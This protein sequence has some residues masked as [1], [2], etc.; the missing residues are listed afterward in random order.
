M[1]CCNGHCMHYGLERIRKRTGR[2]SNTL[3]AARNGT[4]PERN[5]P[6]AGGQWFVHC[7]ATWIFTGYAW[8]CPIIIPTNPVH[9][10]G[11]SEE[12]LV[13]VCVD[14]IYCTLCT[15]PC[16]CTRTG[17]TTWRN[18][19]DLAPWR[20]TQWKPESWMGWNKRS[21][22]KLFKHGL[23]LRLDAYEVLGLLPAFVRISPGTAMSPCN[24]QGAIG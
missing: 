13:C 1:P 21:A 12:S 9:C 7:Q 4:K 17:P 22:C 23:T 10:A 24:G 6:M 19:S 14:R 3:Q 8:A 11:R 15:Q 18:F 5:W 16:R 2:G 20:D